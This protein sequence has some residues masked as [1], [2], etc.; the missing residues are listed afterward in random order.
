M[1]P[2]YYD[3]SVPCGDTI[4]HRN[5]CIYGR[6]HTDRCGHVEK[7]KKLAAEMPFFCLRYNGERTENTYG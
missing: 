7:Q 2:L 3:R 5:A 4:C 1:R 6:R